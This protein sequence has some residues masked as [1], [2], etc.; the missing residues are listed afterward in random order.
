MFAPGQSIRFSNLRHR[1]AESYRAQVFTILWK[2]VHVAVESAFTIP[3]SSLPRFTHRRT[4]LTLTQERK[5]SGRTLARRASKSMKLGY[6]LSLSDIHSAL[7]F[8]TQRSRRCRCESPRSAS[9][10]MGIS[11]PIVV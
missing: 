5:S 8:L 4:V 11:N 6:S 10:R 3:P 1:Y 7:A 2:R 9:E